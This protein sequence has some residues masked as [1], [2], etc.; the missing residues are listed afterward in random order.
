MDIV[1]HMMMKWTDIYLSI[2]DYILYGHIYNI[3]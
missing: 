2:F 1:H 3:F